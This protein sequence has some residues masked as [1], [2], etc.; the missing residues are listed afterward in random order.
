ML[1]NL[2]EHVQSIT[3]QID[4]E[5]GKNGGTSGFDGGRF[6]EQGNYDRAFGIYL[7]NGELEKAIGLLE[8]ENI[9]LDKK[10]VE[11]LLPKKDDPDE[12]KKTRYYTI[13]ASRLN[14]QNKCDI[15]ARLY[16]KLSQPLNALKA[17]IKGG[18]YE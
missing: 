11:K 2:D 17:V 16:I 1:K 3:A 12:A 4:N 7:A 15:A 9:E 6:E 18:N 14:Q 13:L 10:A 8:R 5:G